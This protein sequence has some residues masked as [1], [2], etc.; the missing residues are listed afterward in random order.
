MKI[1]IINPDYGERRSNM[2]ARCRWLSQYTAPDTELSMECLT[3]THVTIDSPADAVLA[4]PEIL[5]M[6][7]AAE[8]EGCSAVVLYCFSDPAAEACR[9]RLSIPVIGGAQASLLMGAL[10]GKRM[11]VILTDPA[12][13]PEKELF[14]RTL[15]IAPE[16]IAAVDAIPFA[17]RPVWA[18]R[19]EALRCLIEKGNELKE[20]AHADVLIPGCL[21]FL[22]LG[23]ALSD[24]TGLPVIDPAVAAVTLAESCARRGRR[25]Y[26]SPPSFRCAPHPSGVR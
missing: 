16:R 17:G 12:R 23:D 10:A 1:R 2:D 6:A 18:H 22:G 19:E 25:R 15:G 11:G 9:Q 4:G 7:E 13:I 20:K 8:A 3:E 26:C 24:A 5:R 14:L 21:S